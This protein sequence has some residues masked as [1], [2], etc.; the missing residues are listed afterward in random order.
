MKTRPVKVSAKKEVSTGKLMVVD[1]RENEYPLKKQKKRSISQKIIALEGTY[2][3]TVDSPPDTAKWI[4]A[5]E[6]DTS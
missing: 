6:N 2:F 1:L 4:R 3:G 5:S